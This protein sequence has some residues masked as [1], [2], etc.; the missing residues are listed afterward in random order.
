MPSFLLERKAKWL[1]RAEAHAVAHKKGRA[2]PAFL[3]G[4]S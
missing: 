1:R 2:N 4:F 3:I